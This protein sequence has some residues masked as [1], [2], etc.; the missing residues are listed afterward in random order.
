[1]QK[2]PLL[3]VKEAAEA[4]RLDERSVRERLTNGTLKG[5]KKMMGLREKWFVYKGAIDSA[6]GK[7]D[8]LD[9]GSPEPAVATAQHEM[10][11]DQKAQA[12]IENQATNLEGS[13]I[14]DAVVTEL[15]EARTNP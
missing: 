13:Y 4:L 6:L 5:E 9:S 3:S 10:P 7:Q 11:S 14:T 1:M 2:H 12:S 15:P 8:N